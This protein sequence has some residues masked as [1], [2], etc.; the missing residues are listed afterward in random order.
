MGRNPRIQRR[1]SRL[2]DPKTCPVALLAPVI[3]RRHGSLAFLHCSSK[4]SR[5]AS[6]W[7]FVLAQHR[8]RTSFCRSPVMPLV[9]FS[10]WTVPRG[11]RAGLFFI[12]TPIRF[13]TFGA[14]PGKSCC[15]RHRQRGTH[16]RLE[17]EPGAEMPPHRVG[18]PGTILTGC[19][20]IVANQRED[21]VGAEAHRNRIPR[22]SRTCSLFRKP[23]SRKSSPI[24]RSTSISKLCR[25]PFRPP[26]H[27][28]RVQ[29]RND[30]HPHT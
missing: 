26:K 1:G 4:S 13:S 28:R 29:T 21:A 6:E 7:F 16:T 8:L 3:D 20:E 2:W 17:N 23:E 12:S 22:C 27:H 10:L 30:Q 18:P 11:I 14:P 24:K 19:I 9:K 25:L 5:I 15:T